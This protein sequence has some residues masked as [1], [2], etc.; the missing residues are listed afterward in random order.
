M[1]NTS[2]RSWGKTGVPPK[3]GEGTAEEEVRI[4]Y[5]ELEI[6]SNIIPV[7]E[8]SLLIKC[9]VQAI[10]KSMQGLTEQMENAK[11]IIGCSERAAGHP[12]W[13]KG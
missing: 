8:L 9:P 1:S 6:Q 12:N 11:T 4:I 5:P 2:S 7:R 13:Q 10:T 3:A